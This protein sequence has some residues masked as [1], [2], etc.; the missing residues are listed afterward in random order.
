MELKKHYV[1]DLQ[2]AL[3]IAGL[4]KRMSETSMEDTYSKRQKHLR[5]TMEQISA[6]VNQK[7]ADE[8]RKKY[9]EL[10]S[11]LKELNFEDRNKVTIDKLIV[12]LWES[13]KTRIY[14][15]KNKLNPFAELS[16]FAWHQGEF[17]DS[18]KGTLNCVCGGIH[19]VVKDM[20]GDKFL[21]CPNFE[22]KLNANNWSK[23]I[24]EFI[25]MQLFLIYAEYIQTKGVID[26]RQVVEA[27]YAT[28]YAF[29]PS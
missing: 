8:L 12:A 14:I 1:T 3:K 10:D 20:E 11:M 16:L 29:Q 13:P 23:L 27:W 19:K 2:P 15:T 22:Y 24:K 5:M 21:V 18:V 26:Y 9:M 25:P 17:Y 4:T 7:V 6:K 28:R